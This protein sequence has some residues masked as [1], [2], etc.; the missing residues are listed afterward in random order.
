MDGGP[1]TVCQGCLDAVPP[2]EGIVPGEVDR[3]LDLV[4]RLQAEGFVCGRVGGHCWAWIAD[5]PE[6]GDG[7]LQVWSSRF[8]PD[9]TGTTTIYAARFEGELDEEPVE[10]REYESAAAAL[11]DLD[12]WTKGD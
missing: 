5:L 6:G 3:R 1:A 8:E 10:Q 2:A 7:Y 11:A 9:L 12:Y 4:H